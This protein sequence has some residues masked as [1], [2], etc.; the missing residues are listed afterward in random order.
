MRSQIL[1]WA[2]V[3]IAALAPASTLASE[4]ED[5]AIAQQI[6]T[7]LR[8]SGQMKNYSVGV[9]YRN[10]TVWLS[11]RVTDQRQLKTALAIVSNL[12]GVENIV[13]G[14]EVDGSQAGMQQPGAKSMAR[15]TSYSEKAGAASNAV[16]EQPTGASRA[17]PCR[18]ASTA[19]MLRTCVPWPCMAVDRKRDLPRR[20]TIRTCR[21]MPGPAMP[22]IQTTRRCNIP[23]NIPLRRFPTSA[24][25]IPI[26]KCRSVGAK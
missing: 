13:N 1:T 7:V 6:A 21:T 5:K 2:I 23:S 15:R 25:S 4:A 19:S 12:E 3:A 18:P 24:H 10:G 22:R 8:D 14:M 17:A 16:L 20:W 11:G 26:R 9:K